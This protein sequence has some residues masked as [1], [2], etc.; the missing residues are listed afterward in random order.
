MTKLIKIAGTL[1]CVVAV[2]TPAIA[3]DLGNGVIDPCAVSGTNGKAEAAAGYYDTKNRK[4]GEKVHGAGSLTFALGCSFGFQMDAAVGSLDGQTTAGVAG[5]A[6]TR[7]PNSHLIGLY[8]D[9]SRVGKNDIWRIGAEG[10]LYL[11]RITFSGVAGFEDSNRTKGDLFA[12]IGA[13]YYI[14]DN[15]RVSG[16]YRRFINIDV[17]YVGAEWMFEDTPFSIFTEGQLGSKKHIMILSGARYHFGGP[18]KSLIRRHREDDPFSLI[19][20]LINQT[21]KSD[22]GGGGGGG[23]GE[24]QAE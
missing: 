5:H 12:S 16:G 23:G 1:A 6:F 3:A 21:P 7:N 15:F 10:E 13:S 18:N 19:T 24:Q 4:G 9:Y 22:T 20:S 14:T 8:S 17:G 11:D 2:N